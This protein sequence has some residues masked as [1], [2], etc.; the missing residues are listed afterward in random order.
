[1]DGERLLPIDPLPSRDAVALLIDRITPVRPGW[2]PDTI[3]SSQLEQL[4]AALDG[5][6]LALEL[7]AARTRVLSLGGCW[8]CSPSGSRRSVRCREERLTPHRTLEASVAWSVDLLSAPDRALLL[9]LW[10]FEGGFPLTA[11]DDSLEALSTLVARSVVVADT[12][13]T[14][15]RYRLLEIVRTSCRQHD[16]DPAASRAV[17]ADRVASWLRSGPRS[18]GVRTQATQSAP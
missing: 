5:I 7:A 15:A 14:P 17:R 4:A 16:P 18:C 11:L 2:H 8:A 10:P 12:T 6:P 3:E 13:V 9:R 1:V